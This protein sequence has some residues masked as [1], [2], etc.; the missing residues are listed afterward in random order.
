MGNF[1]KLSDGTFHETDMERFTKQ[2]WN[3]SWSN[4]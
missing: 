4:S 1:Y 2:I 3:V